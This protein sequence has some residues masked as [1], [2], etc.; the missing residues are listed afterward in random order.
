MTP[1][2]RLLLLFWGS[3]FSLLGFAAYTVQSVPNPKNEYS[4]NFVSNPDGILSDSAVVLI[5]NIAADL[6]SRTT[7]ELAVVAINGYVDKYYD[8][9]HFANSLYNYW[10]IGGGDKSQGVLFLLDTNERAFRIEVGDGCE[11]LLPDIECAEIQEEMLPYLRENDWD[12]ALVVGAS[13]VY[14]K[15]TTDEAVLELLIGY[16]KKDNITSSF[17]FNY[18]FWSF[19]ILLLAVLLA[20]IA[21]T[22]RKNEYNS[23]AYKRAQ[24]IYS[25][26]AVISIIFPLTVGFFA[27]W[28]RKNIMPYVRKRPVVCP[29]CG[30]PMHL[31]SEEDE[32]EYLD[33]KQI[34]E[35]NIK[36]IDY[37]VWR[38]DGC[39]K[40]IVLPYINSLSSFSVCPRCGARTMTKLPD[41]IL[42]SATRSSTGKG[43]HRQECKYCG[44]R[45][46]VPYVIP[47][48]PPPSSSS[49]GSS[50]SY[51]GSSS[52]SS[53]GSWGGGHSSGG[54]STVR[55]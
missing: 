30:K 1:L 25:I 18:I 49:S 39:N 5:E 24:N 35:E 32:D 27:G 16:K 36:S 20:V 2:R 28:F 52:S 42:V 50:R 22:K 14:D 4:D 10:G 11:G 48:V 31:L 9:E 29:D 17:A 38:C 46:I 3:T 19:A 6:R 53:G 34:L 21:L 23:D 15:L 12:N 37:D 40:K 43:L 33:E 7:V 41:K 51:G 45:V 55:F 26:L 54:G 8:I 47:I 44:H 13:L